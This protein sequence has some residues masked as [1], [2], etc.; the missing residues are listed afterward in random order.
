MRYSTA[1]NYIQ[2][3]RLGAAATGV[4]VN[5]NKLKMRLKEFETFLKKSGLI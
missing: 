2:G 1:K 5:H 3:Y 4:V